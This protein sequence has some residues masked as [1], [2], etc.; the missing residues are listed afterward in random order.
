M[1]IPALSVEFGWGSL[2]TAAIFSAILLLLGGVVLILLFRRFLKEADELERTI[3]TGA[4]ALSSGAG[5]IG[6]SIYLTLENTSFVSQ[7]DATH[8]I[9]LMAGA[10]AV[11]LIAGR[12]KYG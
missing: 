2:E 3:Q 7:V 5:F 11:G 6:T 10:Y 8:I 4:L 12:I 9:L 1:A